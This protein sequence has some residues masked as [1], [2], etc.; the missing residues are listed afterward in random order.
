MVKIHL[1]NQN[2]LA[3]KLTFFLFL[4]GNICCGYSLEVPHRGTSNEY[5][6]HM[7]SLRKKEHI[8]ISFSGYSF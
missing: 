3:R 4:E 1:S 7:F 8:C 5:P 6:Q 2:L